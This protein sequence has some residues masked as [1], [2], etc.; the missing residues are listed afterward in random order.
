MFLIDC[1]AQA[2]S[3]KELHVVLKIAMRTVNT[4]HYAEAA[5]SF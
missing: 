5:R 4:K 2:I 1:A 3:N